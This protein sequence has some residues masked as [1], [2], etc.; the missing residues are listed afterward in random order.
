M[1]YFSIAN[2]WEADR[3]TARAGESMQQGAVVKVLDWGDGQRKLMKLTT[4]DTPAVG[5]YG[6]AYKVG[7]DPNQVESSTANTTLLGTRTVSIVSGDYVV[8][9]RPRAI[10]EYS[11]DLLHSSLSTIQAVGTALGIL[12]GQWCTAATGSAVTAPVCGRIFRYFGASR[13]LIE[14]V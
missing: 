3:R 1:G 5:A 12:A 9:V 11:T 7:T 6:V 4:G 13:V 2:F 14:L 10:L 8:E